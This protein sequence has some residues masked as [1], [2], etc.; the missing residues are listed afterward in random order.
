[1]KIKELQT[2]LQ[3]NKIDVAL[4]FNFDEHTNPNFFYFVQHEVS[5]CL[6]VPQKGATLII[7]SVMEAEKTR[8]AGFPVVVYKKSFMET[9]VS[10]VG[11]KK[12]VR[13]GIDE[14]SVTLSFFSALK[15]GLKKI[16]FMN[17]SRICEN[18]RM[19]KTAQEDAYLKKACEAS[20]EIL[21]SCMDQ[22][23][24]FKTE[25][26][27]YDFLIAETQKRGLVVSFTPIVASGSGA[28]QP[29]YQSQNIPL[30]KGFCV[31]DFG[32]K[33]QGYCSDTT[34]TIY[35][36]E[37]TRQEREL[38]EL[39]LQAQ[40][41]GVMQARIGTKGIKT[42]GDLHNQCEKDLGAYAKYFVHSLGHGVGVQIHESPP[43][44]KRSTIPLQNGIAFTIE[45]GVYLSGKVG[46]RIED[47]LIMKNG[48]AELL[49]KISKKLRVKN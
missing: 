44:S 40:E 37:P 11:K 18:L 8:T 6:V 4:F 25:K 47:T 2:Q 45:P 13:V 22:W 1:M 34:R 26:D 35:V 3:K 7:A 32:V 42:F 12:R 33:Y 49:T 5:G 29:H 36:G 43:V 23:H 21:E 24:Q 38:Y 19:I 16:G 14:S 9:L 48:K 27:V 17:I 30:K 20:D 31:I 10:K 41:K 39:V 15:K 46:I 28:S